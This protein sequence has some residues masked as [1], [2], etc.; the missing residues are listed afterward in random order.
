MSK[1]TNWKATGFQFQIQISEIELQPASYREHFRARLERGARG[2]VPCHVTTF[3]RRTDLERRS[4]RGSEVNARCL[5]PRPL[6]PLMPLTS[7]N[8]PAVQA[9]DSL[10]V[11]KLHQLA[12]TLTGLRS[13]RLRHTFPIKYHRQVYWHQRQ[14]VTKLE[15]SSHTRTR[16][17]KF[18]T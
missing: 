1:K 4:P 16:I 7:P 6:L 5:S 13:S 11:A 9:P 10:A 17:L 2:C 3:S 8:I 14:T 12:P 18:N 15:F